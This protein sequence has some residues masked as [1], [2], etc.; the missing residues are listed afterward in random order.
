MC[1]CISLDFAFLWLVMLS[2]FSCDYYSFV[3]LFLRNIYSSPLSI[4][5]SDCFCFCCCFVGLH[6]IF[7]ILI[8][9]QIYALQISSLILSA[10]FSTV[11]YILWCTVY[12]FDLVQF[13]YFYFCYLCF[14]CLIWEI[15]AKSNVIKLLSFVFF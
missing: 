3:C 15:A 10:A 4:L 1:S 14:W 6:H 5:K 13:T 9:H 7:W 12:Y 2:I 11:D 8:F